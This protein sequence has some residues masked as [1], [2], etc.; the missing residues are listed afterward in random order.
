MTDN[1]GREAERRVRDDGADIGRQPGDFQK[2]NPVAD[3]I[4]CRDLIPVRLESVY[5]RAVLGTARTQ[6][7]TRQ[8]LRREQRLNR[9]SRGLI[10]LSPALRT[11]SRV[12]ASRGLDRPGHGAPLRHE[13]HNDQTEDDD[14]EC[15]PGDQGGGDQARGHG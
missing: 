2:V 15:G 14:R 1:V 11:R 7:R 9:T 6:Q 13:R 12:I 5:E 3:Q 4:E 8:R 10:L